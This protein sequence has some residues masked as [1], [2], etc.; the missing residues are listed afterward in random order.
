MLICV[1]VFTLYYSQVQGLSCAPCNKFE[2]KIPTGCKKGEHQFLK[3]FIFSAHYKS[4]D[5][6]SW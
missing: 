6:L 3:D 1:L 5:A 2:C 4:S